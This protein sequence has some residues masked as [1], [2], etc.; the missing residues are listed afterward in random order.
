MG[1][2]GHNNWLRRNR[3]KLNNQSKAEVILAG[4]L[5]RHRI[6]YIRNYIVHLPLGRVRFI[7]FYLPTNDIAIELDGKNHDRGMDQAREV[8]IQ[9]VLP[10]RFVRFRNLDIYC[11][12]D[13]VIEIIQRLA[14]NRTPIE[15]VK[16]KSKDRKRHADLFREIKRMDSHFASL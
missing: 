12:R 1:E 3:L 4:L 2:R 11:R 13:Q 5:S 16:I 8:E 7:D 9:R 10:C 6:A 15:R 14:P